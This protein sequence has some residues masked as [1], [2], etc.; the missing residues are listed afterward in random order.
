M[1][2]WGVFIFVM[3]LMQTA[4]LS[5][6]SFVPVVISISNMIIPFFF[7][8]APSLITG[9]WWWCLV[10]KLCLILCDLMDGSLLGFSVHGISQTGILEWVVISFSRGSSWPRDRT[11]ISFVSHI[12]R[13]RILYV[14]LSHLESPLKHLLLK[15]FQNQFITFSSVQ[16]SLS[17]LSD[18]LWHHELYHARPPCPSPTPRVHLNTCLLSWWGHLTILSSVT[19]CTSCPQ[20]FPTSGSFQMSQ[21]FASGGQSIGVSA[22]ASVLPMNT[23]DWSPLGWIGWISLQ[24]K[25]LSRVFF[26]TI[27]QK[28]QF[29]CAQLSL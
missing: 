15:N 8:L 16:F 3:I 13:G 26:N 19:P 21:L 7:P 27:V 2:V 14:T 23:Q 17:V 20:S 9:W 11:H 5:T 12:D 28:H 25:G 22:S 29:F 1:V 24:S 18:S 10:T 4:T 6:R